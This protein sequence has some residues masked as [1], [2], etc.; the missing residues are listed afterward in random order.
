MEQ[1]SF[2]TWDG[3]RALNLCRPGRQD[4]QTGLSPAGQ[5]RSQG[6]KHECSSRSPALHAQGETPRRV[7]GNGCVGLCGPVQCSEPA[8]PLQRARMTASL[9]GAKP[10]LFAAWSTGGPAHADPEEGGLPVPFLAEHFSPCNR[11]PRGC[12]RQ[13]IPGAPCGPQESQHS[14]GCILKP[15]AW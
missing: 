6:Q 14:H 13:V 1:H 10:F 7:E 2:L 8:A 5:S 12:L 3:H 4:S 9:L 11:K 15:G